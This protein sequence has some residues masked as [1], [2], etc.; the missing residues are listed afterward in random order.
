MVKLN[1]ENTIHTKS[2]KDMD[3]S[4]LD[5]V[6]NSFTPISL[7]EMD[8]VA[9]MNRTDVKFIFPSDQLPLILEKAP[10]IYKV[11]EIHSHRKF[12]YTTTYLDTENFQFYRHHLSG[13]LNR[14][15]VR[16]R[17]YESTATSYLEVKFKSNKMRTVKWRIKNSLNQG[18]IDQLA[19]Q[20]LSKYFDDTIKLKPVQINKFD[21]I[22]LVNLLQKERITLDFNLQFIDTQNKQ[23]SIPYIAIAEIKQE[24][25]SN[26]SP[27]LKILKE[28]NIRPTGFSKYCMGNALLKVLPQNNVLKSKLL[29]LEKIRDDYYF[30]ST[31]R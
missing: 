28:L 27:F 30:Y 19:L 2:S 5:K 16:Y 1:R 29:T 21:R 17:V 9:L 7:E 26:Q 13:K 24:K 18:N 23:M 31:T 4:D 11:L 12:A 15:K 14:F 10:G 20:F 25:Y 6:L 8:S 22:T 3:S